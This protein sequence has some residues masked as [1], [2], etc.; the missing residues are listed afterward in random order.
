MSESATIQNGFRL[1]A[2]GSRPVSAGQLKNTAVRSSEEFSSLL[3]DARPIKQGR[4]P[5]PNAAL[6]EAA[7]QLVADAFILPLLETMH[8][9]PLRPQSGPFAAGTAEKRF[10]PLL[11]QQFADRITQSNNFP[12]VDSVVK[13]LSKVSRQRSGGVDAS[14]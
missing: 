8:S 2:F 10:M 1:S 6:Q 9:S 14:A 12:L 3:N 7:G 4:Q 11:D 13:H 5:E